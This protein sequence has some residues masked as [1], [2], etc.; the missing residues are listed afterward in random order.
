MHSFSS[1]SKRLKAVPRKRTS[2]PARLTRYEL[3]SKQPPDLSSKRE[4]GGVFAPISGITSSRLSI[5]SA[6]R[7]LASESPL[8]DSPVREG[9][10]PN[11]RPEEVRQGKR[12]SGND[13]RALRSGTTPR[14]DRHG[15]SGI[16]CMHDIIPSTE[17]RLM[18]GSLPSHFSP[19]GFNWGRISRKFLAQGQNTT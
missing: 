11:K 8:M 17:L 7:G 10:L 18:T 3:K 14:I 5:L 6:D 16:H 2:T 19:Y 1:R 9:A 15:V 12:T 13:S 4:N